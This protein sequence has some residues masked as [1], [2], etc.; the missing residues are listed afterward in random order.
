MSR[1]ELLV[2]L[3]LATIE[4]SKLVFH[5]PVANKNMRLENDEAAMNGLPVQRLRMGLEFRP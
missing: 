3:S 1:R 4:R 2:G 5:L